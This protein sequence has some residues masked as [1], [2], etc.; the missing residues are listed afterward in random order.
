MSTIWAFDLGKASI[1]EAVWNEGVKLAVALLAL[2]CY[3]ILIPWLRKRRM[4]QVADGNY[5]QH[6]SL[7]WG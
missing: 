7:V 1:G 6:Q 2:D 3:C 4:P 5:R